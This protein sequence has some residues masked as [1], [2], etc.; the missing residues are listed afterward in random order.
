M[1]VVRKIMV[2]KFI[3]VSAVEVVAVVGSAV[4]MNTH[5]G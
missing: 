5:F 4:A 2:H 3:I 1:E